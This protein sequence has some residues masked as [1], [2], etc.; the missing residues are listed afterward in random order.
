MIHESTESQ[1]TQAFSNDYENVLPDHYRLIEMVGRGGMAEVFL[2]EDKRLNRK[3]AIKFLST[4]FR[5]DP[6]RMRRFRQEA[7]SASALN[8]PNILTIH[9]IGES[10]GVQ[11]LVSEFVEGETLGARI[12][13]NALPIPEAVGVAVQVA[14]ALSASHAAGIVHRDIKPDN[15]M[16]RND[17]VVKVLD[18]GLAKASGFTTAN[19]AD[20]DAMTLDSGSTSPGLIVGT[21]QYMSPEQARGKELDG[22]TDVFSL[23]ILLFE[24]VTG[25][26]PFAGDTFADTMAGILTRE[27]RRLDNFVTDPPSGLVQIIERALKKDRN[28]RYSSMDEL[29]SDLKRPLGDLKS[30]VYTAVDTGRTEIRPTDQHSAVSF[31]ARSITHPRPSMIALVAALI[32]FGVG[33][34]FW[35]PK[36]GE[37]AGLQPTMRTVPI[38]SWSSRVGELSSSASF[39]PNAKMIAFAANRSGA[40]E[41]FVKPT[42][43]GDAV[44]VTKSGFHNQYPIWSPNGQEIAFFSRRQG[45][46]GIW[47]AAFTGGQE[48]KVL[49]LEGLAKPVLW[50]EDGK[51]YFEEG[52]ELFAVN[53]DT[54]AREKVSD[55]AASGESPRTIS[56]SRDRSAMAYVV[57]DNGRWKIKIRRKGTIELETVADSKYQ[58]DYIAWD[59]K[60]GSII[61]SSA[62]DGAYQ[63]FEAVPGKAAIQLSNGNQ[64]LFAQDVSA[65]GSNILYGSIAE[66]SDLWKVDTTDTSLSL[67]SNEVASEYWPD[68]SSESNVA[69]QSVTQA[70]R[71]TSGSVIVKH[72]DGDAFV[73][74]KNGFAPVWSPNGQWIAYFVRSDA[75]IEIWRS[76]PTGNDTVKLADDNAWPPGYSTSPYLKVGTN[77]LSWSPDSS[78]IAFESRRGGASNIWLVGVDGA[79]LT[80]VTSNDDK[81]DSYCCP[82]WTPDARSAIVSAAG[83]TGSRIAVYEFGSPEPRRIFESKE[84][85]RV[86]GLSEDGKAVILAKR[87]D[88]ADL[89]AAT[90]VA[91]ILSL[92]LS[93]GVPSKVDDL[94]NTY[95]NNIHLSHD[96]R[97]IAFTT[98]VDGITSIRTIS[99]KGGL[100]KE[101]IAEKDPKVM[102]SS[103][104]W[105]PDGKAIVFGKQTRTHLLSQLSKQN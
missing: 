31:I 55:F 39:S 82:Q 70:E 5:R 77:H 28:D 11:Y 7:R 73:L 25:R 4:E 41:I 96:G 71:P 43:G 45:N 29:L 88:S 80:Q 85:I 36:Q 65:D 22:R 18:F 13:R 16:I 87:R 83:P 90:A 48:T 20:F 2:A 60:N 33:W 19:G 51:L 91:E 26:S 79:N 104:A 21:P 57:L 81:R 89:A 35:G 8:H 68:I 61:F 95:F 50:G 32:L 58:I 52:P 100:Q 94:A 1:Q 102:I 93:G 66:T 12:S 69:F 84:R 24:M 75:G 99:I 67:V 62:V 9:D 6:D 78:Q 49:G 17:G 10:S 72:P 97:S 86:L 103:L 46:D 63:I 64:D 105:S 44:Q 30:T 47:R 42:T 74:A 38:T 40:T 56:I 14:S 34:W 37:T 54:G 3:V 59:T 15:V 92:P 27:P 101:L 53:L 23:G 76:S 98:E